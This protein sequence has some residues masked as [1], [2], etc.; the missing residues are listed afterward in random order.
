MGWTNSVPIFHDDVT[1]IL[2]PKIP[3][4]TLSFIDNV[5]VK[6]PKDWDRTGSEIATHPENP[7]IQLSIWNFA[8]VLNRVI[9]RM[10]YSG[11]TFSGHK[12][13][14][15][16]V[17]KQMGCSPYYAATGTHPLVPIDITEA[18]FL[19]LPPKS[20]LSTTDLISRCAIDLTK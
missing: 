20:L 17:R 18:T 19:Q 6:G 14:R 13:V 16:T 12:L 11:G 4:F 8:Q 3:K 15:V 5:A 2:Q 1:H 10:R 7:N 9:Q